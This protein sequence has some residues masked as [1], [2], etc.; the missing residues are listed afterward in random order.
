M[1]EIHEKMPTESDVNTA[2][3]PDWAIY[4]ILGNF[5]KPL[6]TSNL[7]ITPTFL[8]NFCK[9]FKIHHIFSEIILGNFYRHLAIF[10]RHTG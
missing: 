5:L 7:S 6:A 8:G 9:G 2:V 4:W 10:S 1:M 3:W